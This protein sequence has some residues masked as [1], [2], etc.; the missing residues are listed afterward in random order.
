METFWPAN[1][2]K[3]G[4]N[5][6]VIYSRG[7]VITCRALI[8]ICINQSNKILQTL[9]FVYFRPLHAGCAIVCA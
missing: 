7:E 2:E 6:Q 5:P 9:I 3:K 1:L 4:P 8:E